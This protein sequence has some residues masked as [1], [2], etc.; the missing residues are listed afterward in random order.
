MPSA[1]IA[2]AAQLFFG[3]RNRGAAASTVEA[4]M[5]SLRQRRTAALKEPEIRGGLAELS[6]EQL[7][8]VAAR[9]QRLKPHI[10]QSWSD[11]EIA[12]LVIART[13]C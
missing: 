2:G 12:Q 8:E 3:S 1:A 10:A 4:L 7:V 13:K 9:L 5:Y 6:Y 11:Q